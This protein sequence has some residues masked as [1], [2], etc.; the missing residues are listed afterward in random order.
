MKKKQKSN[1][2]RSRLTEADSR[3]AC[4]SYR[5]RGARKKMKA[6]NNHLLVALNGILSEDWQ[7]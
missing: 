1:I 5:L 7:I 6:T 3:K 4:A 2:D